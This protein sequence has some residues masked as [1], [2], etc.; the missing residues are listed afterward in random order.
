MLLLAILTVSLRRKRE[1]NH[2]RN[3]HRGAR[4]QTT[5]LLSN[6]RRKKQYALFIYHLFFHPAHYCFLLLQ[7]SPFRNSDPG[8]YRGHSSPLPTTAMGFL[9]YLRVH[10]HSFVYPAH[11]QPCHPR[12]H[13]KRE[14]RRSDLRRP[15]FRGRP[16]G[17]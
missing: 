8:S 7:L 14:K 4:H 1:K 12:I 16:R 9:T 10:G 17:L 11:R 13:C 15:W 6:L 3:F 2:T 5:T